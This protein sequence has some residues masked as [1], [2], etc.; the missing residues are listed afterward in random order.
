VT[1]LTGEKGWNI[2]DN[3]NARLQRSRYAR[4]RDHEQVSPIPT[5]SVGIRSITATA[6]CAAHAL[7]WWA[8]R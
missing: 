3:D 1:D 5:A 2:F 4:D 7:A 8:R 6:T